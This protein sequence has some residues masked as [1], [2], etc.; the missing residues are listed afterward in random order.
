MERCSGLAWR[1]IHHFQKISFHCL[2]W[3]SIENLSHLLCFL[4]FWQTYGVLHSQFSYRRLS[5]WLPLAVPF[6]ITSKYDIKLAWQ[7]LFSRNPCGSA[8][9]RLSLLVLYQV[10][11]HLYASF[12]FF[13]R[14]FYQIPT[15]SILIL[16]HIQMVKILWHWCLGCFC[17]FVSV[18][19][20]SDRL[21]WEALQLSY[22]G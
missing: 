2:W 22:I 19:S 6:V 16:T 10:S 13:I 15:F 12:A 17:S 14:S 9:I 4:A 1:I 5:R 21:F 11:Y 3:E 7:D 8:L 18:P 20:K